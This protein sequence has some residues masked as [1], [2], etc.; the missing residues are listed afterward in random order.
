LRSDPRW[1]LDDGVDIDY[2]GDVH[3]RRTVMVT[4]AALRRWP[5]RSSR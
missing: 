4:M 2:S 3:E 5:G 1:A